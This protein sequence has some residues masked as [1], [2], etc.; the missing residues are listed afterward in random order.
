MTDAD[1]AGRAVGG[2][3]MDYGWIMEK[4]T[5]EQMYEQVVANPPSISA[6]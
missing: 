3:G 6:H 2:A 5:S 1:G 4:F